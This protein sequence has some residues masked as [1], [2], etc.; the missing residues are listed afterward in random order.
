MITILILASRQEE[1]YVK[2]F[3]KHL[4]H[5][6]RQFPGVQWPEPF[7]IENMRSDTALDSKPSLIIG[8]MSPTFLEAIFATPILRELI[9]EA[10]IKAPFIFKRCAWDEWP[11]P[12]ADKTALVQGSKNIISEQSNKDAVFVVAVNRLKEVVCKY[13]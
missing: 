10:T 12:F 9:E 13:T 3:W 11:S 8:C 4:G 1:K 6:R 2:E 5:L 7:Y